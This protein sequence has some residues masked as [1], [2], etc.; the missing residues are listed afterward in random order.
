[1]VDGIACLTVQAT[2]YVC[3]L[4]AVESVVAFAA[5]YL[6]HLQRC[7]SQASL[8]HTCVLPCRLFERGL[9]YVGMDYLSHGLWDKYLSYEL[10]L[11]AHAQVTQLYLRLLRMPIQRLDEYR[12]R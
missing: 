11:G 1:M 8:C 5:M 10:S 3:R 6:Q 12:T 7:L 2:C 4:S 9:A